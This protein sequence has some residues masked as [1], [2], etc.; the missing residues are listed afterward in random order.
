M[1]RYEVA[2][3]DVQEA[4]VDG[5]RVDVEVVVSSLVVVVCPLFWAVGWYW[6]EVGEAGVAVLWPWVGV[7]WS[8]GLW[9]QLEVPG[10]E[11]ASAAGGPLGAWR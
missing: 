9:A 10:G 4:A 11:W 8:V 7:R 1:N 3:I 6:R 5:V 2:E